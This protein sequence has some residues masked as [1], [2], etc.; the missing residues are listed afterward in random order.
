MTSE[1]HIQ[2]F[3]RILNAVIKAVEAG[4]LGDHLPVVIAARGRSSDGDDIRFTLAITEG[5]DEA[6]RLIGTDVTQDFKSFEE[7][8]N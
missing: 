6:E 7:Q 8:S 1:D 5:W 2:H 3:E 4:L